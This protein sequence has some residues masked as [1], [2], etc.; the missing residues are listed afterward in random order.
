MLNGIGMVEFISASTAAVVNVE[1]GFVPDFAILIANHGATNPDWFVWA[2]VG[3]FPGWAAA[4]TEKV[5]GSTGVITRDTTGMSVYAGADTVAADETDNTAGKH[6][7]KNGAASL[8]GHITAP[9][10]TVPA[11]HQANSG[12][13]ILFA[14]ARNQ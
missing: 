13:N 3:Q 9:G 12:R 8:A 4:L 1:L 14:F 7:D 5:T 2:N 10:L 6:V 11:D